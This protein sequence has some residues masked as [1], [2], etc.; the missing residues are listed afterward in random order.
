MVVPTTRLRAHAAVHARTSREQ[1]QP[2]AGW[3]KPNGTPWSSWQELVYF[4]ADPSDLRGKI[5][6]RLLSP[7]RETIGKFLSGMG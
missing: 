1:N 3:C 7:E 6:T 2:A 4:S 5:A